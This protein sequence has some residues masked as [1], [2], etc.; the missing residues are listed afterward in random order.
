MRRWQAP[1]F[2]HAAEEGGLRR[3][4]LSP[5][6][7]VE[8]IWRLS[9]Y[10]HRAVYAR[11]LRRR[12][13]LPTRVIS[14]GNLSVG[15]SAKTPVTAWLAGELRE[16][17]RKVAVL[18]RGVRGA[19]R[20][21]VNV[22]SDGQRVLMSTP[23]VGDEPVWIAQRVPGVP[24]LA[25]RNRVALGLRAL[26]LFGV[27]VLILDDGFQH[28]RLERDLDL[29]CI[30]GRLGL[31]NGHVLPRGPLREGI[32]VLERADALLFTRALAGPA[33]GEEW[34]PAGPRRFR[35]EIGPRGLRDLATDERCTLDRLDGLECGLLAAIARPD[36]FRQDVDRLG[37]KVLTQRTFPD[38]HGYTRKDIETLDREL[39]WI[40][41]GKDAVK[42]PREWA[43]NRRLLAL[44]EEV[45]SS[46]R[47][48]LLDWLLGR[49]D[50]PRKL[51]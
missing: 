5:L 37:A 49:L 23:E 44:E 42:I 30:D 48:P 4:L 39:T 21:E 9:A 28:H 34:L 45:Q 38:H 50:A 29:V 32:R 27:E 6:V 41:T 36:R 18:S 46:D 22:V 12:V 13:R 2:W 43:K 51:S 17:G 26:A 24:V 33:P 15:G 8:W 7:A 40:T 31:G 47:A 16:R 3:L 10:L 14:V 35:V 19:S 1:S 25:G 20:R 11:G